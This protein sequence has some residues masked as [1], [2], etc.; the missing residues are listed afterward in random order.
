MGVLTDMI[1]QKKA[2]RQFDLAR[3]IARNKLSGDSTTSL[4][5]KLKAHKSKFGDL[6]SKVTAE[7]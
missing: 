1:V 7:Q 6:I 4:V 5:R 3:Q 2:N